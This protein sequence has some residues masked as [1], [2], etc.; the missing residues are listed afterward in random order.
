MDLVTWQETLWNAVKCM[1]PAQRLPVWGFCIMHLLES[2]R[3]K[4]LMEITTFALN[5]LSS[6]WLSCTRLWNDAD[7]RWHTSQ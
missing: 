7:L 6:A 1:F 5:G 4:H 2:D 3:E